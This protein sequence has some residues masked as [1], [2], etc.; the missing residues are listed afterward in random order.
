MLA[1]SDNQTW[2]MLHLYGQVLRWSLLEHHQL[3]FH[4]IND[5]PPD[6]RMD[7]RATKVV[8]K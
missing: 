1:Q 5:S 2:L 6:E 8:G 7:H 4:G 3:G